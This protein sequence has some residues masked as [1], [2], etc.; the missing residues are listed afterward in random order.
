VSTRNDEPFPR[1]HSLALDA[2]VSRIDPTDSTWFLLPNPDRPSFIAPSDEA[3]LLQWFQPY[4]IEPDRYPL[5]GELASIEPDAVPVSELLNSPGDVVL[6]KGIASRLGVS[7]GDRVVIENSG[8]F[9]ITGLV[10]NQASGGVFAPYFVPPMPWFAYMDVNDPT[11]QETFKVEGDEASVLFVKTKTDAEAQTLAREIEA[12]IWLAERGALDDRPDGNVFVHFSAPT[13][14]LGDR[15]RREIESLIGVTN[16]VEYHVFSDAKLL[17]PGG[18]P[19]PKEGGLIQTLI[20][21]APLPQ[22]VEMAHGRELGPRDTESP[23]MVMGGFEGLLGENAGGEQQRV[24]I[25][26]ALA[27]RPDLILADE[28]TGNLDSGIG[29]VVLQALLDAR[30]ETGTTLV[31]VTHDSEVAALADRSVTMKDGMLVDQT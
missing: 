21:S 30:T 11:A 23:V 26:R 3:S 2:L 19:G 14:G 25:A 5:Y 6:A 29:Q 27:N 8:T 18:R 12:T 20:A 9:E 31:R 28:P 1:E 15:M 16:I 24:A 4:L 7:V 17:S 22:A 10:S 13:P